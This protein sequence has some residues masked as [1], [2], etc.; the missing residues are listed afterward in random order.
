MHAKDETLDLLEPLLEKIRILGKLKEKKRGI[1]YNKS[2]AFLHF[3]QEENDIFADL[4]VDE[5]WLRFPSNNDV[6]WEKI[7][8][9]I[10]FILK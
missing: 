2:I 3:H 7:L 10:K 8:D 6:D 4:K 1:F 9:K 5:K